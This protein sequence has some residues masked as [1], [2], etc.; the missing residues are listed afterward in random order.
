MLSHLR[1]R[2]KKFQNSFRLVADVIV[3]LGNSENIVIP[4]IFIFRLQ[5]LVMCRIDHEKLSTFPMKSLLKNV[6]YLSL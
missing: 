6:F 4:V 1:L 2:H 3:L 5:I